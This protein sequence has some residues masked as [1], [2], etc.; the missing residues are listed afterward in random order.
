MS[1][2]GFDHIKGIAYRSEFVIT[3]NTE[4][5]SLEIPSRFNKTQLKICPTTI[6]P[7]VQPAALSPQSSSS[8]SSEIFSPIGNQQLPLP[9]STLISP[10]LPIHLDALGNMQSTSETSIVE[11]IMVRCWLAHRM[12][13]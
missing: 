6:S 13:M 1:N 7:Q 12:F 8:P 2:S 11:T 5:R 9:V 10:I 3:S 4:G